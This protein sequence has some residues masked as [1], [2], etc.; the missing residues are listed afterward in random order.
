MSYQQWCNVTTFTQVLYLSFFLRMQT[1][2]LKLPAHCYS[3]KFDIAL[4]F[5]QA[6]VNYVRG[7]VHDLSTHS[8]LE[9]RATTN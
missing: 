9:I 8:A 7:V 2:P 4:C 1:C 3:C 6:K 5:G